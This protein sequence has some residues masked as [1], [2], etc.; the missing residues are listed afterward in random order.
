MLNWWMSLRSR[1]TPFT[2]ESP[3]LAVSYLAAFIQA[4]LSPGGAWI[5]L[6][7][8]FP[9]H[10]VPHLVAEAMAR[11]ESVAEAVARISRDH[12]HDWRAL[13]ACWSLAR[14][15]GAPLGPA[16]HAL[17]EALLDAEATRREI[18][19]AMAGP[20]ATMRL[21]AVL[22]LIAVLGGGIGGLDHQSVLFTTSGGIAVLVVALVMMAGA[23]WWLRLL[24]KGASPGQTDWS[25]E[26]DLF[27]TATAGGLLPE[28][29]MTLVKDVIEDYELTPAPT[30]AITD[31]V[32]L[33]RRAGVPV[34]RLAIGGA[35]LARTVARNDARRRV[36][37]LGVHVV[38]PLGFLVLPAF[39]MIAVAPIVLGAWQGGFA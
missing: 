35:S 31:L 1:F 22:P 27:A 26:Q 10:P 2:P 37:R 16:L 9:D 25:V 17:S 38:V 28:R 36:E 32:A 3:G 18:R 7:R 33:S 21:I 5:E 4:G 6:G 8:V 12:D 39:V 20:R 30:G 23:W 29:A 19:A 34:G 13:G 11:H 15:S 24:A 14:L